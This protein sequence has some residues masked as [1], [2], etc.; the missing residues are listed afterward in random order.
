MPS[1]IGIVASS[2]PPGLSVPTL[3]TPP[4]IDLYKSGKLTTMELT[5]GGYWTGSPTAFQWKIT[6]WLGE[7]GSGTYNSIVLDWASFTTANPPDATPT[8]LGNL[9]DSARH[10]ALL[11]R[12][13]NAA[14]WS[15]DWEGHYDTQ[16][17]DETLLSGTSN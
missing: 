2:I 17:L 16:A 1:T 14:G 11:V 10:H 13:Q 9:D 4:T 7:H 3:T 12:A 6:L 15:A 5:S 8:S